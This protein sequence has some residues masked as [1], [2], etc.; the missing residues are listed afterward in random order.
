MNMDLENNHIYQYQ[1][2]LGTIDQRARDI[3][4]SLDDEYC[5]G[6][7]GSR[8]SYDGELYVRLFEVARDRDDFLNLI[9]QIDRNGS[10]K[11]DAEAWWNAMGLAYQMGLENMAEAFINRSSGKDIE[12]VKNIDIRYYY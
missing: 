10:M 8:A 12:N 11:R 9:E 6:R 7:V 4:V 2:W 3:L 5:T 1:K